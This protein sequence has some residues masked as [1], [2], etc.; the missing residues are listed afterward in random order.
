M[1][2]N[3]DRLEPIP[4]VSISRADIKR[5]SEVIGHIPA[6]LLSP[7]SEKKWIYSWTCGSFFFD[8]WLPSP[9]RRK[10]L[11]RTRW[12]E[13]SRGNKGLRR[14]WSAHIDKN[15]YRLI[16]CREENNRIKS[17]HSEYPS[18][19]ESRH[20]SMVAAVKR[21]MA[22]APTSNGRPFLR[23]LSDADG[24]FQS[25]GPQLRICL[26]FGS[27][28]KSYGGKTGGRGTR[29]GGEG[30]G[31]NQSQLLSRLWKKEGP[32]GPKMI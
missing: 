11:S 8:C 23:G 22:T 26:I 20:K 4:V 31:E 30:E 28:F 13:L 24:F 14:H 17:I 32:L 18:I 10:W 3:T 19:R 6:I 5:K 9:E 25:V 27:Q 7:L 15:L 29:G 12:E 16:R 1:D 21:N 2:G